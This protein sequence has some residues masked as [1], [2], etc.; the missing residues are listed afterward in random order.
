M[1]VAA[2]MPAAAPADHGPPQLVSYGPDGKAVGGPYQMGQVSEDGRHILLTTKTRLSAEDTDSYDDVYER[3]GDVTT[4]VSTGPNGGNGPFNASQATASADGSHVFFYTDEALVSADTDDSRDIYERFADAT[5][6][7]STGPNGENAE[8]PRLAGISKDGSRVFFTTGSD[9]VPEDH[10]GLCAYYDDEDGIY[11]YYPC[12]DIYERSGGTTRFVSIVPLGRSDSG[13]AE[14]IGVSDDGTHVFFDMGRDDY[15]YASGIY[16]RTGGN[17]VLVS[18]SERSSSFPVQ[19]PFFYSSG[20]PF[21]ADGSRVLFITSASLV[22]EDT[23][24]TDDLYMRSNG[25]TTLIS[26]PTTGNDEPGSGYVGAVISEGG[27][28]PDF[29]HIFFLSTEALVAEDTG[30]IDVYEWSDGD[31][32]LVTPGSD[33]FAGFKGVSDDGSHVFFNTEAALTPDDK[34][35]HCEDL[36]E[37]VGDVTRLVSTGPTAQL[38]SPFG[39]CETLFVAFIG[40][41]S[42]GSRVF[43]AVYE[44][45]VE[46]DDNNY[47]DD[48]YERLNGETSLISEGGPRFG[49]WIDRADVRDDGRRVYFNTNDPLVASDTNTEFDYY[50]ATANRS[51]DC[52]GVHPDRTVLWPPS[53]DM[54]R[55]GLSGATDPDGDAVTL[56]ITG[57]SQDEPLT[58]RE[59]DAR[60]TSDA[61]QVLLRAERDSKG[62]GRVYRFDF[63]VSDDFGGT[64]SGTASVTVPRHRGSGAVD[65]APPNYDSFGSGSGVR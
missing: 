51:P 56:A 24:N 15:G 50:V 43:F 3:T 11:I 22:D 38:E 21:S 5:R 26:G 61:S 12:V 40:S 16:D 62:D 64:C 32:R 59:G 1:V 52:S 46:R 20:R 47:R 58:G 55:V 34:D 31:I 29:R 36:Y 7:V 2:C 8:D 10:D 49:W 6:L 9:L 33:E 42:D 48:I 54:R 45:L 39:Y 4:L 25:V 44:P 18:T 27:T 30:G 41:S 13:D 35:G 14:L 60:T 28:T 23:D 65:S 17:T 53:K 19:V 37:R 57:V 63:S